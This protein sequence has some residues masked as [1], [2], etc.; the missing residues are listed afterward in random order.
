MGTFTP[1]LIALALVKTGLVPGLI[2]FSIILA[3]GFI[4][5]EPA[6]GAENFCRGYFCYF[7]D[8][9]DDHSRLSFQR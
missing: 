6:A 1:M 2:C 8:A 9:A 5:A 3:V 7:D 4:A